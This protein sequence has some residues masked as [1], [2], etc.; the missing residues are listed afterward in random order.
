MLGCATDNVQEESIARSEEWI[1]GFAVVFS[2]GGF[3]V[4]SA[5]VGVT[6]RFMGS[7]NGVITRETIIITHIRGPITPPITP[8]EPPSR[9]LRA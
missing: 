4:S 1:Q 7:Y 5:S 9:G 2:T 8:H 6:C 3:G